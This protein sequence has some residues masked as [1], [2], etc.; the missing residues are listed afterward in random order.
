ME[1][2]LKQDSWAIILASAM[3]MKEDVNEQIRNERESK[4]NR[5]GYQINRNKFIGIMRD[6][7]I[8]ALT[9]KTQVTL[10]MRMNKIMK[11]AQTFVCPIKPDRTVLKAKNKKK[12]KSNHNLKSNC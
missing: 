8:H 11:R 7:L 3:V 6:D 5:Y 9:A 1:N 4:K 12:T 10:I 2:T